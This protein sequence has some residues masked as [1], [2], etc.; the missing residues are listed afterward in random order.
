[1][2]TSRKSNCLQK[3][4]SVLKQCKYQYTAIQID[5]EQI[6][7][8]IDSLFDGLGIRILNSIDTDSLGVFVF[9]D[10]NYYLLEDRNGF[11]KSKAIDDEAAVELLTLFYQSRALANAA[12]LYGEDI[13]AITQ[14]LHERVEKIMD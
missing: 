11:A 13:I 6:E 12:K 2:T 10:N 7:R 4:F 14:K 8:H 1:M 9:F 3:I 5:N